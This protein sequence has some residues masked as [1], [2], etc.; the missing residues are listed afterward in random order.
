M[1]ENWT[2]FK[3]TGNKRYMEG[4]TI[5]LALMN[6]HEIITTKKGWSLF[7]FFQF[8]EFLQHNFFIKMQIQNLDDQDL[9]LH[10]HKTEK[11]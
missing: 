3:Q 9:F 6:T 5:I 2:K 4:E 11:I 7:F 1:E 10:K 8:K